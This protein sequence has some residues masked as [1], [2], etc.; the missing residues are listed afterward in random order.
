MKEK[1]KIED[2]EIIVR[3]S[4]AIAAPTPDT[5]EKWVKARVVGDAPEFYDLLKKAAMANLQ[6]DSPSIKVMELVAEMIGVRASSG[7]S[8]INNNNNMG[9]VTINNTGISLEDV[10]KKNEER[11][12]N[13]SDFGVES[14][15]F[16]DV[17]SKE[18]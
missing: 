17:D 8:I 6:S 2:L 13:H 18:V 12:R 15:E 9:D 7:I 14:V 11:K 16:I 3:D 10:I 4:S 1:S 5:F